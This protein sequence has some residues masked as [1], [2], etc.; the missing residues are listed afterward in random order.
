MKKV[1]VNW[2]AYTNNNLFSSF[3]TNFEQMSIKWVN[4]VLNDIIKFALFFWG[5]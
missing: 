2:A 3:C 4:I 5:N 1:S